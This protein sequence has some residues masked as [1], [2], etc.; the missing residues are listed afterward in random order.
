MAKLTAK[1]KTSQVGLA[2]SISMAAVFALLLVGAGAPW[3]AIPAVGLWAT[4]WIEWKTSGRK[5]RNIAVKQCA[6]IG[7]TIAYLVFE[8]TRRV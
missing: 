7:L 8:L 5:P 3:A 1:Q 2:L 6:A 4:P